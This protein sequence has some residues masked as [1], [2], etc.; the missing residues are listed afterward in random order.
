MK[1]LRTPGPAHFVPT[2]PTPTPAPLAA[3]GPKTHVEAVFPGTLASAIVRAATGVPVGTGPILGK[4]LGLYFSASWCG[5]CHDFTAKLK[6]FYERRR[7]AVGDFEVV[8]I[9]LDTDP[10]SAAAYAGTMP[11]LAL[12]LDAV[13]SFFDKGCRRPESIPT[14][15]LLHPTEPRVLS[16]GRDLVLARLEDDTVETEP[17][18][19]Q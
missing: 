16:K 6:T 18:W 14:L 19:R 8:L 5:P 2:P 12:H 10:V 3:E 15:L 9:S 1:P 11:W 17:F 4:V 13:P 7:R